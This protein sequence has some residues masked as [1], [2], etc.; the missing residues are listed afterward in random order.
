MKKLLLLILLTS[1]LQVFAQYKSVWDNVPE[2]IRN[3]NNFKRYEWFYRSRVDEPGIYPKELIRQ[4]LRVEE[5]KVEL[6]KSLNKNTEVNDQWTVLGPVGINM[7]S[8][9]IPY[10]GV[11]SGRIRGLDVHPTNPNI[12]YIGASAGGIW[13]T[14]D[15]GASWEDKSASLNRLTFG[16]I[17]IDPGNTSVIYAGTGESKWLYNMTTFEG[18]GLYKSTDGGDSWTQSSAIGTL[19]QFSD[20]EVNPLNSNIILAA[21]AGGHW[22][23]GAPTNLGVWRSAD[24]GNTW[25][26]VLGVDCAFDVAFHPTNK[27]LA[28]CSIGNQN[29]G[30]GFLISTNAGVTWLQ[31]NTGLPSPTSIGRMQFDLCL[32]AP[33]TIYS[34]IYNS[35]NL[36]GGY[37][38]AAFRSTNGGANWSQI[39]TGTLISGTY[40]GST[41]S[42]QGSYDLCVSVN[43]GNP[44][45]V[46]FGNVEIAK[47]TDGENISFVRNPDGYSG[48]FG[49]WD[50][51]THTDIHK[52]MFAPS[53]PSIVYVGCDGGIYKSTNGGNTFTHINN[54]INTIQLYRV[55]SHPTNSDILFGGAQ[56]NGNFS[57]FNRGATK[58]EFEGSGDG[59]ECFVDYS[60][61]NNVYLSTQYGNLKKSDNGGVDWFG[62]RNSNSSTTAWTAP[63]WQHPT[64]PGKI[65]TASEMQIHRSTNEGD[66]WTA[67]CSSLGSIITSI[68]QSKTNPNNM[69]AVMSRY[70]LTPDVSKSSDEGVTW[71]S[72][73][74][75]IVNSGFTDAIIQRVTADP[76]NGNTFYL[77]RASYG[78]GQVIITSDFGTTWRD[79]SGNLPK[80]SANDIFVDP[81][82]T[83]HIYVAN[84]F[85]VYLSFDGGGSYNKLSNGM[86]FVPVMDFDFFNS[87][88]KKY[89]RAATHGRGVLEI[90]IDSPIP[91]E[92]LTFTAESNGYETNLNWSTATELNNSGFEIQR[93]I[94]HGNYLTVG[95]IKGNGNSLSRKEYCF[96][97]KY[98]YG[99]LTYR[100]KQVDYNGMYT[101][102]DPVEIFPVSDFTVFQNYPNPFNPITIIKFNL[103]EA[104]NV[105]LTISNSLGEIIETLVNDIKPAGIYE[106]PW[107]ADK[108]ASG[109][110]FYTVNLNSI[111]GKSKGLNKTYKMLLAK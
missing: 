85:G 33:T 103:P 11:N 9:F 87:G 2:A 50:G 67:I 70:T 36:N 73:T 22:T 31:S 10:W 62:I 74:S 89:L 30:G 23:L 98:L 12:A 54:N 97:E 93:S 47:T 5:T 58:W 79:I 13:K 24:A 84:D 3:S 82:N 94:D 41:I 18:D 35:V 57:T 78:V 17:A 76:L 19:T 110:Y 37:K 65:Y 99:F 16:A 46:F 91:V 80:V 42:D 7:E 109:V 60:N 68:D 8:S 44:N 29:S 21:I 56:D 48:G 14:T 45:N 4:Q 61:P 39:S 59:M 101:Y 92:F 53:N 64:Q 20:I 51:Y 27:N 108:Y 25:T 69:I 26:R 1:S 71:T 90:N 83:N 72:I 52:I 15:G 32:S 63:F 38:T 88:G 34:V 96:K 28:Y 49:A 104:G 95:F 77:A 107:N 102:S 111:L 6:S 86:P 100:L 43:P 81:A 40:N 106:Y 105:R 75:N 55:A 66:T